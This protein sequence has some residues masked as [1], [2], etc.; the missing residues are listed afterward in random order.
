[1]E[2]PRVA[3]EI[4]RRGS[5]RVLLQLPDGVRPF[6][7][8]MVRALR[9][10]TGVQVLLSGDSC[11]GACDLAARQA[12]ELGADL[13]VHYGHSAMLEEGEVPV[14]YV[15]AEVD[16]DVGRLVDESLPHL[17]AYRR[18]GVVTT[19][20]HVHQVHEVALELTRRGFEAQVGAGDGKAPNTGQILG[21]HYGAAVRVAGDVDAFLYVG[22]GGFHPLGLALATGKPVVAAD[23]YGGSAEAVKQGDLMRLA[24]RRMAGIAAARGA[25]AVGILA[26]SK[27]GQM[28]LEA[29]EGLERRFRDRGVEAAVVYLDEVRA[30]HLNNYTEPQAFVVTACPRVALDGVPGV[31]RPMLT[32]QEARVALGDLTWDDAWGRGLLG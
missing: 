28:D 12:R 1:M 26:S 31:D 30:E 15:H 8:Q 20:Q 10:A 29:A 17:C 9:E 13:L 2:L 7:W 3:E 4:R 16:V 23:P 32:V 19:V 21:C 11:Y 5:R 18:V 25:K 27:P 24:K 6:A 22:G 14:I